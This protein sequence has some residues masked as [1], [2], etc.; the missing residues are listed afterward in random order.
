MLDEENEKIWILVK[1]SNLVGVNLFSCNLFPFLNNLQELQ[2]RW[3][4]SIQV[5]FDIESG[6]VG[7][8][9]EQVCTSS[10]RS[11]IVEE[12][13]SLVN[14]LP[15]NPMPLF[16]HLEQLT[17]IKCASIEVIF[18]ID[19]GCVSSSRLRSI[20]LRRLGKLR[21]VWRIKDVGNN[22]IHG[23]EAVERIDI[24]ECE[25]F[26]NT[27]TLARGSGK[28]VKQGLKMKTFK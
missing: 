10:L 25:R 9:E 18:D 27:I 21:E 28:D 3:C 8:L 14:L 5:L 13:D 20:Y 11:I 12:C 15:S 7:K 4:G 2:V 1:S 6:R 22:L 26:E 17:V 23:F 24:R 19:M 16:N